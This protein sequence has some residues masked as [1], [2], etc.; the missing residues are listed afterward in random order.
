MLFYSLT[1]LNPWTGERTVFM[2]GHGNK[3]RINVEN[4]HQDKFGSDSGRKRKCG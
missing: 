4:W 2:N 3:V 1:D